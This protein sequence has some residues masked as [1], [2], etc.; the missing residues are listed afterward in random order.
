MEALVTLSGKAEC[1]AVWMILEEFQ[2]LSRVNIRTFN[3]EL[4]EFPLERDQRGHSLLMEAA[5][6]FFDIN[7]TLTDNWKQYWESIKT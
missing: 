7:E 1:S 5:G 2:I 4:L 3:G 6:R